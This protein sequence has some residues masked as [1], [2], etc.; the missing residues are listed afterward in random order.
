VNVS[1]EYQVQTAGTIS[2]SVTGCALSGPEGNDVQRL[3]ELLQT[4]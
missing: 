1:I 4:Y 3:F 2:A